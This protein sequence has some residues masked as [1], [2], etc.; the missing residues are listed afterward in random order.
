MV[1]SEHTLEFTAWQTKVKNKTACHKPQPMVAAK[2]AFWDGKIPDKTPKKA[3][4]AWTTCLPPNKMESAWWTPLEEFTKM[5]NKAAEDNES[6]TSD[7]LLPAPSK[8][9]ERFTPRPCA[10]AQALK[11]LRALLKE[12]G[13][14]EDH[15][16]SA[17][18]LASFRVFLSNLA[19]SIN[20]SKERRQ[21]LGKWADE[22]MADTYT[23]QHRQ[24][25][26]GIMR[27][28]MEKVASHPDIVDQAAHCMVPT[29]LNDAYW[30][31]SA[32]PQE[33]QAPKLRLVP[34][35]QQEVPTLPVREKRIFSE[36]PPSEGGPF[37]LGYNEKKTGNPLLHK[38]HIFNQDCVA[39]GC[40]WAPGPEQFYSFYEGD[41]DRL[42]YKCCSFCWK[43]F[44]IPA[45]WE[46]PGGARS[47]VDTDSED[48]GDSEEEE[49]TTNLFEE[50]V[51]CID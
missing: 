40:K 21:W 5:R 20:I 31:G 11:W 45:D 33:E 14:V 46:V 29:D 8:N 51:R 15:D 27:E 44:E 32:N 47:D 18:T 28:I 17:V 24:V 19:H 34:D 12:S 26:L 25:V 1:C 23:R 30:Q 3:T 13:M 2:V 4:E 38:L 39:V 35:L 10:N 7:F 36:V 37:W 22:N 9:R 42:V 16:I 48:L 49:F 43:D 50:T 41:Y 6:A